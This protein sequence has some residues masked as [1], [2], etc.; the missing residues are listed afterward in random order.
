MAS[1]QSDGDS[2]SSTKSS[3]AGGSC[4]CFTYTAPAFAAVKRDL[5]HYFG[6]DALRCTGCVSYYP[7]GPP[8]QDRPRISIPQ[9]Y[10]VRVSMSKDTKSESS[11]SSSTGALHSSTN[12]TLVDVYV[13]S[14][15]MRYR[16]CTL[17]KRI[18]N[19][20]DSVIYYALLTPE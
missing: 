9:T 1:K 19:S 13:Y 18:V 14:D 11:S 16:Y 7:S 20:D 12:P 5:L 8:A 2:S 15:P 10:V 3:N 6:M 4:S 17:A